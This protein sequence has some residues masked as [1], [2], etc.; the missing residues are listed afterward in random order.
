M[1]YKLFIM[2]PEGRC[3]DG[4]VESLI[5]PGVAGSFGILPHHAPMI[6]ALQKGIVKVGVGDCNT[7]LFVIRGGIAEVKSDGVTVLADS[8]EKALNQFDAEQK[9]DSLRSRSEPAPEPAKA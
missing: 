1:S 2:T 7:L 9:L 8:A 5:A 3:F 6:V 4:E